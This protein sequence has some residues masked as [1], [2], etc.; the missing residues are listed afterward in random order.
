[1]V[2]G[3]AAG[4]LA[5]LAL[6][7]GSA[8]QTVPQTSLHAKLHARRRQTAAATRRTDV[9]M[10][11]EPVRAAWQC[12]G[13]VAPPEEMSVLPRRWRRTSGLRP[14][15]D[16]IAIVSNATL[17]AAKRTLLRKAASNGAATKEVAVGYCTAAA[18][19]SPCST[20][21]DSGFA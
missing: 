1:M 14:V 19:G 11:A 7:R 15:G 18:G 4:V 9:P 17:T 12:H 20:T 10:L 2:L 3:H 6:A 21:A 16:F 13:P 5:A 8:V